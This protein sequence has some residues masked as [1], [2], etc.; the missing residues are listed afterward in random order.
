MVG[1]RNENNALQQVKAK[2]K[3]EDKE[4][5]KVREEREI[6]NDIKAAEEEARKLFEENS[7]KELEKK[8]VADAIENGNIFR[9]TELGN[10]TRVRFLLEVEGVHVDVKDNSGS[11][12]LIWAARCGKVEIAQMLMRK[13]ADVNVTNKWGRTALMW[14]AFNGNGILVF[15]LMQYG[16]NIS[17]TD[18]EGKTAEDLANEQNHLDIVSKLGNNNEST[19]PVSKIEFISFYVV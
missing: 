5:I 16:A 19:K 11:T 17:I 12:A 14:A 9:A 1:L 2:K 18:N 4:R 13:K 15:F 3:I 10:V 7:K 6:E 8:I